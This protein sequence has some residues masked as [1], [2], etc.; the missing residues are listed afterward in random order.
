[1][2][3][4]LLLLL[5]EG[6]SCQHRDSHSGCTGAI[7]WQLNYPESGIIVI[8]LNA[9]TYSNTVYVGSNWFLILIN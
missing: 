8:I 6:R 5:G 4:L 9:K 2:L 3:L 7:F 1:L